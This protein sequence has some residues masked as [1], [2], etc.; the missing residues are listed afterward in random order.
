MSFEGEALAKIYRSIV[1]DLLRET[2]ALH[3]ISIQSEML[4]SRMVLNNK[5]RL[6][7]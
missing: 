2:E 6:F 4:I 1:I 3:Y 5:I 7:N